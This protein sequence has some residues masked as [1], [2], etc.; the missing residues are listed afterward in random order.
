MPKMLW[1]IMY[2]KPNDREYEVHHVA[3]DSP[4]AMT[5]LHV[6]DYY[7]IYIYI[8]GNID[9]VV[10]EKRYTPE[11]YD[12]FLFPPG[13][14]H[15]WAIKPDVGRYERAFMY[16][17]R[18][19]VE[20]MSSQD[21]SMREILD[22]AASQHAY[23]FR[24]GVHA[25]SEIVALADEAIRYSNLTDAAEQLM[26]RC[27][28]NML[29]VA[30]CRLLD[31]KS[32]EALTIPSRMREIITYINEHLTEPLTLDM[33]AEQFFVSKYYLLHAFKDYANLSLHQYI[34]SKRVIHAQN[35]MREGRSPGDA[36]RTSGFNDYAGFYRA[37]IKQTGVT[38]QAF[39]KGEAHTL[40]RPSEE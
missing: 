1:D 22:T 9:I 19:C 2:G 21:F 16:I 27:R 11:P 26:T 12:L 17:T 30:F 6:H 35:L 39:Y 38:P 32:E 20:K 33:L 29:A 18:E 25:G 31:P 4:N 23:S 40:F 10:E 14:M 28:V 13:V 36:A 7:E 3:T 8:S 15:R 5:T 34:I 24:P 37:F